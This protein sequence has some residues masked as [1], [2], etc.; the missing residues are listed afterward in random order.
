MLHCSSLGRKRKLPNGVDKER[1]GSLQLPEADRLP[2]TFHTYSY[3]TAV[4]DNRIRGLSPSNSP[5]ESAFWTG[6]D[7]VVR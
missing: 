2:L 7:E 3:F 4:Q 6:S 5:P 1:M